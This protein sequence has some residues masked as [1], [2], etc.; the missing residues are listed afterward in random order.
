VSREIV[1]V[2]CPNCLATEAGQKAHRATAATGDEF[3]L[4]GEIDLE[5]QTIKVE[6]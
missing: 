4:V 2:T 3:D 6:K 5:A 1:A